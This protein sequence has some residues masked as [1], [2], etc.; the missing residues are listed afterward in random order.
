MQ[1]HVLNEIIV[2]RLL[3]LR[4]AVFG[5]WVAR[6]KSN[7]ASRSRSRFTNAKQRFRMFE[8][9]NGD[10][11]I[12]ANQG[13]S[14]EGI[15]DEASLTQVTDPHDLEICVHG[16]FGSN[17]G[18]IKKRGLSR[19]SHIH[20]HCGQIDMATLGQDHQSWK[21][22][23]GMCV[24]KAMSEGMKFWCS[25]NNVILTRG[26]LPTCTFRPR[27]CTPGGTSTSWAAA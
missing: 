16:T 26:S 10:I 21:L 9:K 19:M 12:C 5:D 18:S 17:W 13:H 6:Y 11:C 1:E 27:S 14:L 7:Q 4:E 2:F 8:G 23:P 22:S 25:A 15:L 3:P 20:I 24:C